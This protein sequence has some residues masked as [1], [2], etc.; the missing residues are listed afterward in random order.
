VPTGQGGSEWFPATVR[1]L[2]LRRTATERKAQGVQT[3]RT[4]PDEIRERVK[5]ER[6]AGRTYQAIADGL[7]VDCPGRVWHYTTIRRLAAERS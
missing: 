3:Q 5:R 1:K 6:A 7:A 4:I 2:F